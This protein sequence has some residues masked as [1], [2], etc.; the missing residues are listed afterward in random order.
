MLLSAVFVAAEA[1]ADS[2][3]VVA[4]L[5]DSVPPFLA[6]QGAATAAMADRVACVPCAIDDLLGNRGRGLAF[7]LGNL[8]VLVHRRDC[9]MHSCAVSWCLAALFAQIFVVDWSAT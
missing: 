6:S 2:G 9:R 5:S 8:Q 4:Q 7:A 3:A 1:F